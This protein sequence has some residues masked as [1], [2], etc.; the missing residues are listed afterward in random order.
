MPDTVDLLVRWTEGGGDVPTRTATHLRN[1]KHAADEAAPSVGERMETAFQRLEAREP[2]MVLR[3]SAFALEALAASSVAA[4]GP[5]GRLA[6][7]LPLLGGAWGIAAVAAFAAVGL[8]IR[9][10]TSDMKEFVEGTLSPLGG[11]LQTAL[12]GPAAP[13]AER[14]AKLRLERA[15]LSQPGYLESILGAHIIGT[16]IGIAPALAGAQYLEAQ[17]GV[18]RGE[19]GQLIDV[20]EEERRTQEIAKNAKIV[21]AAETNLAKARLSGGVITDQMALK[22]F[23]LETISKEWAISL[24]AG[25]EA[26]KTRLLKLTDEARQVERNNLILQ[27]HN[28]ALKILGVHIPT[29]AEREAARIGGRVD[30]A[31]GMSVIPGPGLQG[32]GVPTGLDEFTRLART[33]ERLHIAGRL[34][35]EG[36]WI[37]F[38][39]S[40]IGPMAPGAGISGITPKG[41]EELK[42]QAERQLQATERLPFQIGTVIAGHMT[43]IIAGA[44]R[45]QPGQVVSGIGGMAGGIISAVGALPDI[46]KSTPLLGPI[47]G[48]VAASTAALGGIISLFGGPKPV[49]VTMSELEQRAL[50]QLRDSVIIPAMQAIVVVAPQSGDLLKTLNYQLGRVNRRDGGGVANWPVS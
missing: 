38:D 10:L 22:I 5:L 24:G 4:S 32:G 50:Q 9:A 36:N 18:R 34:D 37:P 28:D 19:I 12:L 7:T 15:Q 2:T 42:R 13:F 46:A 11:Q 44:L 48:I 21:E 16:N 6:A 17:R 33:Q 14:I 29:A 31:P 3:R 8:A 25:D 45:G 35:A 49:R 39:A 47:G 41:Q 26:F 1:L 23:D 43:N 30:L 20:L 40:Q 27:Q